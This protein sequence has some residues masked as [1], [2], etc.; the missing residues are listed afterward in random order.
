MGDDIQFKNPFSY[1][2]IGPRGSGKTSF[3]IRFL[4]TL[5]ALCTMPD[6][7]VEIVLCYSEKSAILYQELA[8]KKHDRFHEGVPAAFNNNGENRASLS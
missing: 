8:G 1:L 5:K 4:Q 6:F 3:S 2:L 7:S